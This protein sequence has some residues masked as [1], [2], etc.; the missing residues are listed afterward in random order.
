MNQTFIHGVSEFIEGHRIEHEKPAN[1][2]DLS[3]KQKED[4]YAQKSN[5]ARYVPGYT[6]CKVCGQHPGYSYNSA[7][8]N[9]V[10]VIV[11]EHIAKG[12]DI[13]P[14]FKDKIKP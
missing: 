2:K 1:L 4:F 9:E 10:Q 5:F 14:E 7:K 3:K 6:A 11:C 12:G 8:Q 13:K